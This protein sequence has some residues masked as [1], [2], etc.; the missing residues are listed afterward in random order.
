M[1][2]PNGVIPI[3]DGHSDLTNNADETHLRVSVNQAG[4]VSTEPPIVSQ[5]N[6]T[7]MAVDGIS[8]GGFLEELI[9]NGGDGC[10][11]NTMEQNS[12]TVCLL[13]GT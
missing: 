2:P 9:V 11:N 4:S 6:V 3:G 5:E 12:N 10:P 13:N 1:S 7:V 8:K